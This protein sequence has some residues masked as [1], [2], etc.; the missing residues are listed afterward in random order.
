MNKYIII[1]ALCFGMTLLCNSCVEIFDTKEYK[2]EIL[3]S[4]DS[5][6]LVFLHYGPHIVGIDTATFTVKAHV[7]MNDMVFGGV[8][9]LPTGGIAF[10][11]HRRASSNTWGSTLYVTDAQYNIVNKYAICPSPMAP[12]VINN[13]LMVGSTAYEEGGTMKFQLYNTNGFGL[14]KEFL[15][16]DMVDAW[17]IAEYENYAYFG[18]SVDDNPSKERRYSYVVQL[19]LNNGNKTEY[20]L[21]NDFFKESTYSICRQDSI[22]YVFNRTKKDICTINLNNQS[23]SNVVPISKYPEIAATNAWNVAHPKAMREH[24]YSFL[25]G[26]DE[27]GFSCYRVKLNASTFVLEDIKEI[28]MPIV[29]GDTGAAEQFL[30][31]RFLVSRIENYVLFIDV[32]SGEIVETVTLDID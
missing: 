7:R 20:S 21:K 16:E 1:T 27:Q 22:L 17:I 9:K 11:H 6:N 13:V 30:A 18:V 23:I 5:K 28:K 8:A 29:S 32:E 10:T 12:K 26:F 3:K 4:E 31:G 24:L 2:Y 15:F 19:D 25:G 14:I